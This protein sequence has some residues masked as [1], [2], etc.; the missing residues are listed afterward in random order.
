MTGTSA[1][2]LIKRAR[3]HDGALASEDADHLGPLGLG[4]FS[5]QFRRR[6]FQRVGAARRASALFLTR[7]SR[8]AIGGQAA[9]ARR[10]ARDGQRAQFLEA[11][12]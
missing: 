9:H 10:G 12:A 6:G 1:G 11:G 5:P 4:R 3:G 2:R 8:A 7:M